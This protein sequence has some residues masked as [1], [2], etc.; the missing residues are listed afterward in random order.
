MNL[1]WLEQVPM[2]HSTQW[3]SGN[4]E[5]WFEGVSYV[6]YRHPSPRRVWTGGSEAQSCTQF[7]ISSFSTGLTEKSSGMLDV[8]HRHET[9][10]PF[11]GKGP[12]NFHDFQGETQGASLGDPKATKGSQKE[13]QG[14]SRTCS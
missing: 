5:L 4:V 11:S 1:G 3:T 6:Y 13:P 8:V 14:S 10:G 12:S 2:T 9:S 7:L